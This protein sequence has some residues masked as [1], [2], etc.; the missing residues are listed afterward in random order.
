[1]GHPCGYFLGIC[2]SK[3][4]SFNR[5]FK[6]NS[7]CGGKSIIRSSSVAAIY[8]NEPLS[9][10]SFLTHGVYGTGVNSISCLSCHVHRRSSVVLLFCHGSMNHFG[11]NGAI[12]RALMESTCSLMTFK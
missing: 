2:F 4:C 7:F 5:E 12:N 11:S 8:Q 6:T 10:V 3:I 1:M 9:P